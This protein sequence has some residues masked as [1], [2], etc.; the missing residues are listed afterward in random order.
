ML[1]VKF[2]LMP[3][4]QVATLRCHLHQTLRELKEHFASELKIPAS[5]IMLTFDGKFTSNQTSFE[6]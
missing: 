1:S 4:Q 6:M 5:V 2:M 3:S